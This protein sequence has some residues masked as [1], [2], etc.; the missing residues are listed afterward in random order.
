MQL[1]INYTTTSKTGKY[2]SKVVK[3]NFTFLTQVHKTMT[4]FGS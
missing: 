1:T 2:S 3:T 4:E